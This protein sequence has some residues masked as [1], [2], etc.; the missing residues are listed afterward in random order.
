[1]NGLQKSMTSNVHSFL[2]Y[3][4]KKETQ[5]CFHNRYMQENFVNETLLSKNLIYQQNL[6]I[7]HTHTWRNN[8]KYIY[9]LGGKI[10]CDRKLHF[11]IK[12]MKN[13]L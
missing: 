1:M 13:M 9:L 2:L 10:Y 4:K 6:I 8:Q 7:I 12:N 5:Y 11:L 3:Y